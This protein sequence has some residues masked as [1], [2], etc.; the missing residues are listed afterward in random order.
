MLLAT[1]FLPTQRWVHGFIRTCWCALALM[2][3]ALSAH[4]A[5]APPVFSQSSYSFADIHGRTFTVSITATGP[6]GSPITYAWVPIPDAPPQ[7]PSAAAQVNPNSGRVTVTFPRSGTYSFR[8]TA[9]NIGGAASVPV[10]FKAIQSLKRIDVAPTQLAIAPTA[11]QA[12]SVAAY[13]QFGV[14]MG[15][16]PPITWS[17][18][19]GGNIAADG[20][21]TAGAIP[22]RYTVIATSGTTT[23]RGTIRVNA[24]PTFPAAPTAT[25]ATVISKTSR[26]YAL[27]ADDAGEPALVYAWTTSG[28][29]PAPVAFA[30]DESKAA[31]RTTATFSKAG[32]YDLVGTAT[33]AQGAT[34]TSLVTVVVQQTPARVAVMPAS[35]AV[36]APGG[37]IPFTASAT[38]QFADAI[39]APV[40]AWTATGG[41]IDGSGWFTAGLIPGMYTVTAT[42]GATSRAV[43]VRVNASPTIATAATAA[44]A[45]VTGLSTVLSVLGADDG[46]EAS[47][48]Y[49]WAATGVVP[50]SVSFSA[51]GTHAARS[52]R[53][54]FSAAG[55]YRFLVTVEDAQHAT[56]TSAVTVI[57]DQKLTAIRLDPAEVLV[58]P[59]SVTT[60]TATG[61]DQFGAALVSAPVF[62]WRTSG[63]GTLSAAGQFTAGTVPGVFTVTAQSGGKSATA[64]VRINPAPTIVASAIATPSPVR[65]TTVSLSVLG[66]DDG[67]EGSLTYAW[68]TIGSPPAEVTWSANGTNAAKLTTATFVAAGTY[69]CQVTVT[70]AY[71]ATVVSAV[72]VVVEQAL[73]T[74]TLSPATA[75]LLLGGTAQFTANGKDQF[76]TAFTPSVSWLVS[77]ANSISETGLMSAGA[78]GEAVVS[79]TSGNQVATSSV[80]VTP[81]DIPASALTVTITGSGSAVVPGTW[82]GQSALFTKANAI[83]VRVTTTLGSLAAQAVV[84][85]S[86]VGGATVSG[87]VGDTLMLPVPNEGAVTVQ[88]R[89]SVTVSNIQM[90][91]QAADQIVVV[92]R[93][94]PKIMVA[95]GD[96]S[97]A[98]NAL[99]VADLMGEGAVILQNGVSNAGLSRAY[100]GIDRA[101]AWISCA[102]DDLSGIAD[103]SAVS[104]SHGLVPTVQVDGTVRITGLEGIPVSAT[105]N[106]ALT[107]AGSGIQRATI[108]VSDRVG[109]TAH[110]PLADFWRQDADPKFRLAA[111]P[112]YKGFLSAQILVIPDGTTQ[113]TPALLVA[114][115]PDVVALY[116]S[117]NSCRRVSSAVASVDALIGAQ[118]VLWV[119]PQGVADGASITLKAARVGGTMMN[120]PA[121]TVHRVDTEFIYPSGQA[122]NPDPSTY[123][124]IATFDNTIPVPWMWSLIP[125]DPVTPGNGDANVYVAA[126][127]GGYFSGLKNYILE[128]YQTGTGPDWNMYFMEGEPKTPR[129][130]S[131]LDSSV[132]QQPIEGQSLAFSFEDSQSL[133]YGGPVGNTVTNLLGE[134]PGSF[135]LHGLSDPHITTDASGFVVLY[136]NDT[137]YSLQRDVILSTD[138]LNFHT[139]LDRQGV[140]GT[141]I[142]KW[143]SWSPLSY[144]LPSRFTVGVCSLPP[145]WKTSQ[146]VSFPALL[147]D[148][149][150]TEVLISPPLV[151]APVPAT[152]GAGP[153]MGLTLTRELAGGWYRM[154]YAQTR[155]DTVQPKINAAGLQSLNLVK[156]VTDCLT[157][158]IHQDLA[159][160]G[161]FMDRSAGSGSRDSD[162]V[163]PSAIQ[164]ISATRLNQLLGICGSA[165]ELRPLADA[166]Q[167]GI[168]GITE[169]DDG[170][171]RLALI[172]FEMRSLRT[173]AG[174]TSAQL[175]S[176]LNSIV[177]ISDPC[178]SV[179]VMHRTPASSLVDA[180]IAADQA[181]PAATSASGQAYGELRSAVVLR[182]TACVAF[183]AALD[184]VE[185]SIRDFEQD[186]IDR[187]KTV[188]DAY[189]ARL[190][191][192]ALQMTSL[193]QEVGD[194][195]GAY[196]DSYRYQAPDESNYPTSPLQIEDIY[197]PFA[198]QASALKREYEQALIDCLGNQIA[199]LIPGM[200]R[201]LLYPSVATSAGRVAVRSQPQGSA[202]NGHLITVGACRV[203]YPGLAGASRQ[204]FHASLDIGRNTVGLYDLDIAVGG[205]HAMVVPDLEPRRLTINTRYPAIVCGAQESD[206][207]YT[208]RLQLFDKNAKF[209]FH[210]SG[211][212][213]NLPWHQFQS[214]DVVPGETIEVFNA[215][216]ARHAAFVGEQAKITGINGAHRM[217]EALKIVRPDIVPTVPEFAECLRKRSGKADEPVIIMTSGGDKSVSDCSLVGT[218]EGDKNVWSFTAKCDSP[219]FTGDTGAYAVVWDL[220][221]DQ[222]TAGSAGSGQ[223]GGT[224]TVT[225]KYHAG[226]YKPTLKV[227]R[228]ANSQTTLVG[229]AAIHTI[230]VYS[231]SVDGTAW[232]VT[233]VA[234][235]DRYGSETKLERKT[236]EGVGVNVHVGVDVKAQGTCRARISP[237]GYPQNEYWVTAGD[238]GDLPQPYAF[239]PESTT[240]GW[241]QGYGDPSSS[242]DNLSVRIKASKNYGNDTTDAKFTTVLVEA[243]VDASRD[244][245][246]TFDGTDRTS[247]VVP[248]RFWLN[249]DHDARGDFTA[250]F[251]YTE[252]DDVEGPADSSGNTI[253][254]QRDLEDFT[255]YWVAIS[256]RSVIG[257]RLRQGDV[258]VQFRMR[259]RSQ[260][261][262]VKMF[263][264]A[265]PDGGL[266]YLTDYSVVGKIQA[267]NPDNAGANVKYHNAATPSLGSGFVALSVPGGG[268]LA[269][270]LVSDN[271]APD[272]TRTLAPFLFEGVAAGV[273]DLEVRITVTLDGV[274]VPLGHGCATVDLR[275]IKQFYEQWTLGDAPLTFASQI[276]TH[277]ASTL[278]YDDND[279]YFSD[280]KYLLY[281]HGWNM[282]PFDKDA[283]ANTAYKRLWWNGYKGR[284][285]ALRWPTNNGF[286]GVISAI[287]D[288]QNYDASE[289]VALL[290]GQRLAAWLPTL[291]QTNNCP[292]DLLGHS[293]GNMV[294]G[295][296]LY[297]L[298]A[299]Q[300]NL[301]GTYIASQAA[302]P[303]E[304]YR[305]TILDENGEVTYNGCRPWI[306]TILN[307]GGWNTANVYRTGL[308]QSNTS[309]FTIAN[310]CNRN[311]YALGEGVSGLNQRLK[312]D[313]GKGG[314]LRGPNGIEAAEAEFR[315]RFYH[316]TGDHTVDGDRRSPEYVDVYLWSGTTLSASANANYQFQGYIPTG[317]FLPP[318]SQYHIMAYL[319][320]SR[321][322]PLGASPAIT[323]SNPASSID[324][325][326]GDGSIWPMEKL[327]NTD[328]GLN[329]EDVVYSTHRWHSAQFRMTMPEQRYYWKALM[330]SCQ[331]DTANVL[332]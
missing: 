69:P 245:R 35:R 123:R 241:T 270:A 141:E 267:P 205:V 227:Y 278:T 296:A 37:L 78:M 143:T 92:D 170:L 70:D 67:G 30:P 17:V 281:V 112:A 84:E 214:S 237:D 331:Y 96:S 229:T 223:T 305:P 39:A 298:P 165:R 166:I 196:E 188:H 186:G 255:R 262:Q 105:V 115:S 44:P 201:G 26:L 203:E 258:Q 291:S 61:L 7:E 59:S 257:S 306:S 285:G 134:K 174:A 197:Y 148:D 187:L 75:S 49:R 83:Q 145:S 289:E 176:F 71:G 93:T 312:P 230:N 3:G 77:G 11:S 319:S 97:T 159:I 53:V 45:S 309:R 300:E 119:L 156:V 290:T 332:P 19:G 280:Q 329:S 247:G 63:G 216:K 213:S 276:P 6:K 180:A 34:A 310:F 218:E 47:L 198:L 292:I 273:G 86:A 324:V 32:T 200:D 137:G 60:L 66:A 102:V 288:G 179:W 104:P 38:D 194:A 25:P 321:V 236:D 15:A 72:T 16:V 250:G 117:G 107:M 240:K 110:L 271:H 246:I 184:A 88:A 183:F 293:M 56:V 294:V 217:K 50:G 129:L 164:I 220:G 304:L 261:P 132:T 155:S 140:L 116:Q 286:T 18:N 249:N 89:V 193:V 279:K 154:Q 269:D 23:G 169:D 13:D 265:D 266:A 130:W 314:Y 95:I 65:G 212:T 215:R 31:N 109:N 231:Q 24:A 114:T 163:D 259:A 323:F 224:L 106:D 233:P 181:A 275:D 54:T 252:E 235:D 133:V 161:G 301:V 182:A 263:L 101:S 283:F 225:V 111:L 195:I 22:G 175:R 52:T 172:D 206:A 126:Y 221:G 76:G 20:V 177:P 308:F 284:Y 264:A 150:P 318:Q 211:V 142:P 149:A 103:A 55:T 274:Q 138:A 113:L 4:A 108:D 302:V 120:L 330:K 128:P 5:D 99:P 82:Q 12:Y 178:Y 228:T 191:A 62:T 268:S 317:G 122:M 307:F 160:E 36:V 295:N 320:E 100:R 168:D 8:V 43:P 51:N 125:N 2:C 234:E 199:A 253:T 46:G 303:A 74:L 327:D 121:L 226:Q 260:S 207:D 192:N 190:A 118:P 57:V 277:V 222:V 272:G 202:A 173:S 171:D 90:S 80:T 315:D 139:S 151:S 322:Y 326:L 135:V 124:R 238:S 21:F 287:T 219:V 209:Y 167:T 242:A 162:P 94:P 40:F 1:F 316:R 136:A 325:N 313:A 299:G 33:D 328:D 282:A 41:S 210:D 254:C 144:G 9:T 42:C 127:G 79:A 239:K 58:L 311:D 208:N 29:P 14:A 64:T 27:A 85:V 243:G 48:T 152:A 157:V 244:Q 147:D 146:T 73:T 297:S 131:S 251:S 158:G 153:S 256:N 248:Y 185:A 28:T 81:T 98:G 204:V 91:G 68:S 232:T 10:T 189:D 87:K